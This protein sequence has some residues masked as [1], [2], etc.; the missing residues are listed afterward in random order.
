MVSVAKVHSHCEVT[1]MCRTLMIALLFLLCLQNIRTSELNELV[2][3][4]GG[5]KESGEQDTF[6]FVL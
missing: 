4:F 1:A 3:T 5:Q 6:Q 2:S